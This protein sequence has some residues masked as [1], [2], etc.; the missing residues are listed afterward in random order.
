VP[1]AHVALTRTAGGLE[2]AFLA[3]GDAAALDAFDPE[4]VVAFGADTVAGLDGRPVPVLAVLETAGPAPEGADRVVSPDPFGWDSTRG[5]PPPWRCLALPIADELYRDPVTARRPPRPLLAGPLPE[6]PDPALARVLADFAPVPALDGAARADADVAIHL[7][8]RGE[9]SYSPLAP[10]HLAAGRL[11]VAQRFDP[12]FGLRP[13][14]DYV[15]VRDADELDLRLHQ[16]TQRPETYDRIRLQGHRTSRRL[17]ASHVWPR[18][19]GDLFRDLAAFGT[20]RAVSV[21]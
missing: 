18:L 13:G 4:A 21:S 12:G 20:Q 17:R 15:E 11:L 3:A 19:L 9:S 16:L 14:T 7:A 8:G 5:W 6:D 1:F 10:L 2:P